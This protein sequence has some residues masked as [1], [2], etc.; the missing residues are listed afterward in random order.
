MTR[1]LCAVAIALFAATASAQHQCPCPPEF[2]SQFGDQ[3]ITPGWPFASQ[4][5][6]SL[7]SPDPCPCNPAYPIGSPAVPAG[8][9]MVQWDPQHSMPT[10]YTGPGTNTVFVMLGSLWPPSSA[11]TLPC[12]DVLGANL[13]PYFVGLL[14]SNLIGNQFQSISNSTTQAPQNPNRPYLLV[15]RAALQPWIGVP[16]LHVWVTI[17]LTAGAIVG[18]GSPIPFSVTA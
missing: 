5:V 14:S 2:A 7:S 9:V 18:A 15:P 1:L 6:F 4:T 17:D 11:I 16:F 8:Y 3:A 12:G 10:C 13:D